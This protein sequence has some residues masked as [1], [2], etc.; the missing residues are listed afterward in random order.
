VGTT[1]AS[2]IPKMDGVTV[3]SLA[4]AEKPARKAPVKK[5]EEPPVEDLL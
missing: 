1:N 3:V 2:L 4:P 5:S